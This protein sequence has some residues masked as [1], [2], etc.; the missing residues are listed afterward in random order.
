MQDE[1]DADYPELNIQIL[2]VNEIGEEDG[3]DDMA[4]LG[5][6]PLLQDTEEQRAWELWDATFRDVRVVDGNGELFGVFNLT[7][8]GLGREGHY[9]ALKRMFIRAAGGDPAGVAREAGL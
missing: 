7:T 9:D 2:T 3:I 8:Y 4:I 5:D 6:I 1:F